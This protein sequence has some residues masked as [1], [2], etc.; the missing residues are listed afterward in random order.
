VLGF[1]L[2][3]TP[4]QDLLKSHELNP[5][6]PIRFLRLELKHKYIDIYY[7]KLNIS[8]YNKKLFIIQ[9]WFS[10]FKVSLEDLEFIIAKSVIYFLGLRF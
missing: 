3:G 1:I 8:F 2:M 6:I 9:N 5:P 10:L 7:Y 4:N